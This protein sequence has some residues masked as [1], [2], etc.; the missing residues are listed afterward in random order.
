MP[1][2]GTRCMPVVDIV[3]TDD[4]PPKAFEML[5]MA[6]VRFNEERAGD[7]RS[8]ILSVLLSDPATGNV[9]GGLWGRCLWGSMYVDVIFVPKQLRR[10]GIGSEVMQR[11]EAEAIRRGCHSI[12]LDTY[13]FQALSF[14]ER[15]GFT[16]FGVIEGPPPMFPH[17]FLKKVL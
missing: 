13:N 10:S 1:I 11:A 14:Y 6:L 5:W 16:V 2:I 4:P 12:W 15:L 7:S 3:V 8:D 9:V 17:L